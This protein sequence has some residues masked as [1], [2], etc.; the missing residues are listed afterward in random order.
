[1]IIDIWFLMEITM[2]FCT[3]FYEK[4]ILIM[5]RRRIVQ[6]YLKTWFAMDMISSFPFSILELANTGDSSTEALKSAKLLRILRLTK[7]ARLVR[8]IRFLKLNKLVQM[9][10]E[11]IVTEF[12]NLMMKFIKMTLFLFFITHWM[13]CFLFTIG[14][15]E[16]DTKGICWIR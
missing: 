13:A 8:L 7:Y 11:L 9:L 14:L 16:C 15:N 6:K 12:A 2:N 1:M 3:G 5:N 4:G 10:D